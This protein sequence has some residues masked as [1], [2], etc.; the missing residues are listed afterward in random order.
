MP[1]QI[2]PT[3]GDAF[4]TQTTTLDGTPYGLRFAFSAREACFYL[5]LA[6]TDGEVFA[7]GRKLVCNWPLLRG[8]ASP[9]RPP[10]RLYVLSSTTDD[11]PPAL[12]DLAP[13][14][15]C[16][17]IYVPVANVLALGGSP[18]T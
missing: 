7:A 6:T 5:D 8:C 4:W 16:A 1:A 10:G 12:A 3:S 15:R 13:G 11:S 17:L 9:L 18:N 14:G 2:I